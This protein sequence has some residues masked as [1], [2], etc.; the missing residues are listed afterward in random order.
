MGYRQEHAQKFWFNTAGGPGRP[1]GTDAHRLL[2][3]AL[4]P[5][6]LDFA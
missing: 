2:L 6:A 5:R 1:V 4:A 3:P